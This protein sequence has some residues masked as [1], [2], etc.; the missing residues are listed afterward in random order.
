MKKINKRKMKNVQ[1]LH[2]TNCDNRYVGRIMQR[3][4]NQNSDCTAETEKINTNKWK[5]S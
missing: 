1:S 5:I 4:Y 2:S 3:S